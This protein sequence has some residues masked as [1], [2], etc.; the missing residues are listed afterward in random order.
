MPLDWLAP[1]ARFVNWHNSGAAFGL[2]QGGGGIFGILAIIVSIAILIYYPVISRTDKF[3]RLALALQL[4]GA[5]GNF[6]DRLTVG[7][8]TDFISIWTFPVF[9][10]ADLS[11]TLGV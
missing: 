7:A 2:F 5:L 9:N 8:V 11:I 10:L 1:Y 4:A 3:M 6:V